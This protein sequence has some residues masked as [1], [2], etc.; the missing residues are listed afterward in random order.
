M[1]D[2]VRE[3]TEIER[4]EYLIN[5]IENVGCPVLLHQWEKD[6]VKN[7]LRSQVNFLTYARNIGYQPT[8]EAFNNISPRKGSSIQNQDQEKHEKNFYD[9][10]FSREQADYQIV[11]LAGKNMLNRINDVENALGIE[12]TPQQRNFIATGH[13]RRSGKTTAHIIKML[14]SKEP[15]PIDFNNPVTVKMYADEN[16]PD[17]HSFFKRETIDIY[18]KLKDKNISVRKVLF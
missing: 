6:L 1:S 8:K 10:L 3:M 17:Y 16:F 4:N 18:K 5:N 11:I 12:L 9:D 13:W 7:A 2:C 15:G 14:M